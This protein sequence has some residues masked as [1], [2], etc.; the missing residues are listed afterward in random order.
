MRRERS[1]AAPPHPLRRAGCTPSTASP[2]CLSRSV[3]QRLSGKSL[4]VELYAE[5]N[6]AAPTEIR[7]LR[8]R[9]GRLQ[10]VRAPGSWV[11]PRPRVDLD[12]MPDWQVAALSARHSCRATGCRGSGGSCR[13]HDVGD[14]RLPNRHALRRNTSTRTEDH[15]RLGSGVHHQACCTYAS[16]NTYRCRYR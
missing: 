7:V 12:A 14:D 4:I 1:R 11:M 8:H 16:R 10:E 15:P 9:P 6:L 3:S 2:S 13:A 5:P